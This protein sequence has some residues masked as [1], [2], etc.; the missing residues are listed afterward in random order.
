M[1]KPTAQAALAFAQR[2]PCGPSQT[3]YI[4]KQFLLSRGVP[5]SEALRMM[6]EIDQLLSGEPAVAPVERLNIREVIREVI[7]L[8]PTPDPVDDP[9]PPI[10]S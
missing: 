3:R 10:E 7:R 6:E 1:S 4:A 5:I 9:A 2:R 8:D